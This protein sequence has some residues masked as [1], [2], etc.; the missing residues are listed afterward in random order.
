MIITIFFSHDNFKI[1]IKIT[2]N[3]VYIYLELFCFPLFYFCQE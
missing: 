3:I 1:F 2:I